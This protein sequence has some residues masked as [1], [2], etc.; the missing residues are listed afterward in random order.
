MWNKLV[1]VKHFYHN[2][3]LYNVHGNLIF[4]FQVNALMSDSLK[5]LKIPYETIL[6]MFVNYVM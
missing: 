6:W 3:I 1:I 5:L 4:F 2:F